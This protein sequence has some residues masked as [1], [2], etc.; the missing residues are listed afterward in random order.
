MDTSKL[1][2][3]WEK[4]KDFFKNMSKKLRIILAAALAVIL[5]AIVVTAILLSGK[6]EYVALYQDM[7]PSEIQEVTK[8]ESRQELD[9]Y[10]AGLTL[11]GFGG[12]DFTPVFAY[13][14]QL[15]ETGEIGRLDGLL[16][17]TD[18]Y[19]RFPAKP[20]GYQTAFVFLD[21]EG[22]AKVPPWAMKV[23]LDS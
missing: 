1:K 11:K 8:I 23:Y 12:T 19:G 22:E 15:I 10:I 21:R 13:V 2:G 5:I 14:D 6:K 17:F 7:T 3:L 9:A 4:V 18:G 20:P 16:Y